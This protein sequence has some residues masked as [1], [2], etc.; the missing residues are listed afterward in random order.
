MV[1]R[2]MIDDVLICHNVGQ[3]MRDDLSRTL[4][5][6]RRL[7]RK[8]VIAQVQIKFDYEKEGE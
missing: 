7:H 8:C 1:T 2:R 4:T 6:I 5:L 3:C